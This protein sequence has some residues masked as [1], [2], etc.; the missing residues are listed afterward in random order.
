MHKRVCRRDFLKATGAGLVSTALPL[1]DTFADGQPA[2]DERRV[3]IILIMA[4][5]VSPDLYG[6][7]GNKDVHTP[8]LDRMAREGVMFRTCWATAM[9]APTRAMIMTGRYGCRT[10]YYHNSIHIPQEDGSDRLFTYHHSFAKLLR[11]AGYATA[12]AGKWHCS[13]NRPESPEVGFD[14][15]CLW[16]SV[17][18]IQRLPGKPTFTGMWENTTDN[19]TTSRYWHPGIIRN[20]VL[21]KTK[22]TDFGPAIFTDFLCDFMERKKDQPF[23]AY[24]PMVSPHGT[25][26]GITTTPLYGAVGQMGRP[27]SR[28]EAQARF[29]ALNEY[30]DVLVGRLWD[31]VERLGLADRTI[32]IF[33]SDNGTAVT[34]KTRAVERGCRVPFIAFGGPVKKRGV[35]D[36]LTDLTDILPT[37]LDFAGVAVPAGYELDGK[38]LKPFLTGQASTHR[39]WIYSNIACSVLVRTKRCLLEAVN[40]SLG[41]PRGRLYDCGDSRDGR[42]YRRIS[43]AEETTK[44]CKIFEPILKKYPPLKTSHPFFRSAKGKRFLTEYTQPAS[45]DKHLHNHDDYRFYDED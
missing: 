3:N 31:E 42:G 36:E 18:R 16:E 29:R 35:T 39:Q 10:G 27:S 28:D 34:A 20:H 19:S 5:D 25:R 24:F 30:I 2:P 26:E 22:P 41:L 1:R 9:C 17:Q 40:P 23:L 33:T 11:Q 44:V 15:Y 12:I 32:L 38:S 37:L 43:G 6:C 7:Y 14:E 45:I 4:D 21:A 8:N 13:A